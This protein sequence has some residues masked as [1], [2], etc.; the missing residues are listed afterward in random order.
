M[1]DKS[2]EKLDYYLSSLDELGE[3]LINHDQTKEVGMAVLRLILGTVMAP[4]GALLLYN[5]KSQILFPLAING[6][7]NIKKINYPMSFVK[8]MQHFSGS[9]LSSKSLKGLLS[10]NLKTVFDSLKGEIIVPLFYRKDFFG[11]IIISKKFMNI[12][13]NDTDLKVLEIISN[14]LTNSIFNQQLLENVELKKNELN[15]K[16]L[17]L[18]A[19]FDI[20][21]AIS[22]V[23][24]ESELREE[25]LWRSV[26]VLNVSKGMI[27]LENENSPI[28]EIKT[29]FNWNVEDVLLSKK[30]KIFKEINDQK[31]GIIISLDKKSILQKKLSEDNI[32]IAPLLA[33]ERCLGYMILANKETRAGSE[34]FIS[35]D[36]DLLTAFSNQASVALDNAKLFKDIRKEKQ[37]NESILNSIATGL[38]TL[39]SLGEIDSVNPSG[40]NILG[41]DESEIIGNHYMYLFEK[42]PTI[43]ELIQTTEIENSIQSEQN[44]AFTT[45]SKES[46][47]NISVSPRIGND[48]VITGTVIAIEDI[49]QQNKIK[50]TFKRYVSKQIV[51]KLLDSKE[52]LNLGGELRNVTILFTDI[53][54]FTSMSENMK[55]EEV[56]STLND[57]FTE[58]I[59][60]VFK[61]NGTL[62]KIVGDELMI[63]YGAPIG[64]ADDTKRALDTA[65]EMMVK[66][67]SFNKKRK[68]KKLHPIEIGIG[69]NHG[70]VISGNIGSREMMDY[71]VI[72]DTV[73][74]AARLCSHSPPGNIIVSPSV[75]RKTSKFYQYEKLEP[76]EVKGKK[77]KIQIQKVLWKKNK[78]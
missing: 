21:L 2:A 51:E 62:D 50:N 77:K 30:L 68:I 78:T 76:I 32:I 38:L 24:N 26:G 22:S 27:I 42:D 36:L 6:L 25:I 66:L 1:D 73:N 70:P 71:T 63:V 55:P 29:S 12:A 58:M 46:V 43:L 7:K 14:H 20:S 41:M 19:L 16:L 49:T 18:E 23:L 60:I 48:M 69:I 56:V 10:K 59:D 65:I 31:K 37:F 33:K 47:V 8:K 64:G 9:H 52:G 34:P 74:L 11:I 53:R 72:G 15:L 3:T 45:V 39:D 57:Y 61:H 75:F 17:E 54:G 5:D 35:S 28:L 4:K 67:K 40:Q 44:I 13:Y